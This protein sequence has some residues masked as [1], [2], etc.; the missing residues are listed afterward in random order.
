M[1][2]VQLMLGAG[3]SGERTLIDWRE[4]DGVKPVV[5]GSGLTTGYAV[6]GEDLQHT[7]ATWFNTGVSAGVGGSQGAQVDAAGN[8]YFLICNAGGQLGRYSQFCAAALWADPALWPAAFTRRR[9]FRWSVVVEMVAPLPVV[10]NYGLGL[11]LNGNAPTSGGVGI[12]LWF[13]PVAAVWQVR[14][15]LTAGGPLVLGNLAGIGGATRFLAEFRYTEAG[16][17][18]VEVLVNGVVV[19]RLAGLANLPTPPA[20]AATGGFGFG[21]TSQNAFPVE[22]RMAWRHFRYTVETIVP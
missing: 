12:D 4:W 1:S 7:V 16:A 8:A 10:S 9:R 13:D 20:L 2:D 11:Y 21:F 22:G 18:A 17:P 5:T 14:W 3:R 15:R 19:Q 6:K